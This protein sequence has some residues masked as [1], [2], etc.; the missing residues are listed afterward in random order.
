MD[1]QLLI[2]AD[3]VGYFDDFTPKFVKKYGNV[4]GELLKAF[5]AYA[6]EV[7]GGQFPVDEKHAYIIK[8]EEAAAF[9]EALKRNGV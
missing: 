4:G 6:E 2:F 8:A 5:T 1:G 3:M 7:R 9:E